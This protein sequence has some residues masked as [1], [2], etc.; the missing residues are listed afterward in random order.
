[1]KNRI[2]FVNDVL[3]IGGVELSLID[4]LNHLDYSQVEV[5]LYILHPKYDL[6][7]RVNPQV[8]LLQVK[9][10]RCK[11]S[12]AYLWFYLW[13]QVFK[14]LSCKDME[15]LVTDRIT[16]LYQRRRKK[17]YFSKYYDIVIAYKHSEATEFVTTQLEAKKKI[18]FYHQGEI[19]DYE[20]H[21]Q[22]F[23][24]ATSIVTVSPSV[25]KLLSEAYPDCRDKM[26]V[27]ENL[28]DAATILQRAK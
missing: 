24:A 26:L 3:S 19:L 9:E 25:A 6:L 18:V 4:V 7:H 5:D 15:A 8:H 16:R 2:L 12:L 20:L 1:M 11:A 27:I 14:L 21:K 28:V 10:W 13:L 17:L 22:A 23:Q